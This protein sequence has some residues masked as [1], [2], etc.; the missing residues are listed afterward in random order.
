MISFKFQFTTGQQFQINALKNEKFLKVLQKFVI[1]E[2]PKN[3]QIKKAITNGDKV[4]MNQTLTENKIDN[5]SIV[6]IVVE[7]FNL[8]NYTKTDSKNKFLNLNSQ[9]NLNLPQ[10]MAFYNN[11][12][13]SPMSD[14]SN[15]NEILFKCMNFLIN[16]C[17]IPKE[18]FDEK[19]NCIDNN[20][21]VGKKIGPPEY[22]KDYY[23]PLGWIG[24][25]L[26]VLNLYDNGDNT[27]LSSVNQKGEWLIAYHPIKNIDSII[28]ILNNGFRR[29]PFQ[30][31]KKFDNINPLTNALYN[32]CG[33]GAYFIPD[34]NETK[35]YS[36]IF[37]YLGNKFRIALMCRI[38]PYAVRIANI[39]NNKESWIVN[40]DLLNDPFGIKR[41]KEVRPYKIILFM[42]N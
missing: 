11:Y 6:L 35:K 1:T 21:K 22:L 10:N 8:V 12:N 18:M 20:W 3:I 24:I 9:Q 30:K 13:L 28:G 23:P 40:G 29:G 7:V 37:E 33:E 39:R 19:W 16:K 36:N 38:N 31:Y 14:I 27:W 17:K 4:K 41:D 26:K 34:I 25:G 32:K 5:G 15:Q 42:E 2:C